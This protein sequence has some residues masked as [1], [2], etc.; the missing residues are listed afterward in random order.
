MAVTQDEAHQLIKKADALLSACNPIREICRVE[1]F[2]YGWE[3]KFNEL[4]ELV[5]KLRD[6]EGIAKQG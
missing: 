1:G 5:N 3:E 6:R 2:S 4:S